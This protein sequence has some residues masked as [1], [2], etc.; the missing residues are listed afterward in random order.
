KGIIIL[1]INGLKFLI[2]KFIYL[3]PGFLLFLIGLYLGWDTK[4]IIIPICALLFVGYFLSII[5][6]VHMINNNERLLSAFDIK[7][8]IKII[9]SVGVN[10]YIKF[11]LYLTSVIIG[12]A[13]L[14]LFFISIISW[15][16]ILFINIIF[17]SK[18]YLYIDSLVILIFVLSTL[19]GIFILL[20]I[21]T[22]LESRATS[23]I[24]NL[25]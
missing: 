9:K 14:S 1:T 17:F 13:S 7:S 24:Y 15:L 16:I 12:V 22:I 3:L 8:I 10:T 20:P 21:Y 11:Y 18:Y 23:S 5:A 2:I 25:R 19:F 4:E 6:K